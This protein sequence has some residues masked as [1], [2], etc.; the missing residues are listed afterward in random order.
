MRTPLP[1]ASPSAL[2]TIGNPL[3]FFLRR[4]RAS[5]AE[6][7]TSKRAVGILCFFMNS[8]AKTLLDSISAAARVAPK[9]ARSRFW[10]SSTM[11]R[12]SGSSGPTRVRSMRIFSAKSASS[13]MDEGSIGTRS[14]I[15]AMPTL[16]GA[17][18]NSLTAGLPR[19]FQQ[20]ACSRA[21]LPTTRTFIPAWILSE[22]GR[23]DGKRRRD[24]RTPRRRVRPASQERALFHSVFDS[25]NTPPELRVPSPGGGYNPA[26]LTHHGREPTVKRQ[27]ATL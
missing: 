23:G 10:N 27:I 2:S 6:H 14:A 20:R 7:A 18:Y 17:Q 16:P 21:P 3:F 1:A 8:L 4:E 19:S 25:V 5:A 26:A 13:T 12:V 9:T 22:E 11:P 24:V 15:F